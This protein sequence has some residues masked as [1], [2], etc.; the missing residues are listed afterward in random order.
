MSNDVKRMSLEEAYSFTSD[1]ATS[2][3]KSCGNSRAYD[4]DS[5]S[6]FHLKNIGPLAIEHLTP[7]YNDSLS[8]SDH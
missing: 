3:I 5:R 4:P 2:A 1:Q 7:L 8:P 6:I